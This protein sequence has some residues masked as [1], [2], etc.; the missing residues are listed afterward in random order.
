MRR[1]GNIS[2]FRR[3]KASRNKGDISGKLPV[4]NAFKKTMR[5]LLPYGLG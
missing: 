3:R 5:R 2:H 4:A 1:K